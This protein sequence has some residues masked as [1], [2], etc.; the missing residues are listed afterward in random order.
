MDSSWLLHLD[1]QRV[2]V[3]V[4]LQTVRRHSKADLAHRLSDGHV[5]VEVGLVADRLGELL[6]IAG[7]QVLE[8][9]QPLT[10]GIHPFHLEHEQVVVAPIHLRKLQE[11]VRLVAGFEAKYSRF[12][13]EPGFHTRPDLRSIE[14]DP[15][16][17]G[18]VEAVAAQ[19]DVDG[20]AGG[21]R[22][23]E[24]GPSPD[25]FRGIRQNNGRS[26][27]VRVIHLE[28]EIPFLI[29]R[30][31][32]RGSRTEPGKLRRHGPFPRTEFDAGVRSIEV[33]G[34]LL[35]VA[36]G[37]IFSGEF[38]RHADGLERLEIQIPSEFLV[39]Y[40]NTCLAGARRDRQGRQQ[41]HDSHGPESI[42]SRIL[43]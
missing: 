34:Q 15:H 41:K 40:G 22:E 17:V 6:A 3:P 43:L 29:A 23:A 33:D 18:V 25:M 32:F 39:L 9:A 42:Y 37:A 28:G 26:L 20:A 30:I 14:K 7:I 10:S 2:A 38:V 1:N 5:L 4:T 36:Q 12:A 35:P 13:P 27:P 8:S 21:V 24:P 16:P 31:P 19:H 11:S